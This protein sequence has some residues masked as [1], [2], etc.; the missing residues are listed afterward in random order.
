[1]GEV[2]EA[3]DGASG[4][5][6]AVKVLANAAHGNVERFLR[7]AQI[8][9]SITHP[10][11][12]RHL[13]HGRAPEGQPYLVMEW[14]EGEDLA[15]RLRQR[16]LNLSD[17]LEVGRAV[18]AGLAAA[19]AL[20]VVHRDLKP[21]NIFLCDC[22]PARVKLLDFGL[23]KLHE[24]GDQSLTQTGVILG[25][26]SYMAPEQARGERRLGPRAD[27]FALGCILFACLTRRPPFTG[28][29]S[30]AILAKILFEEAPRL[31][32]L[33][34]GVPPA[35]DALVARML[36]KDPQARP[37]DAAAVAAALD[38]V[39]VSLAPPASS[40]AVAV[41]TAGLAYVAV[42]LAGPASAADAT[43]VGER[44]LVVE[45]APQ[46]V[47]DRFGARLERL[48]DGST[49][50]VFAGAY[51]GDMAQRAA[52][53]ALALRAASTDQPVAVALGRGEV[54]G[55]LPTGE[56]IDS[57]SRL[58]PSEPGIRVD[59]SGQALLEGR[60]VLRPDA[61]GAWLL[62]ARSEDGSRR[63]LGRPSLF[64]GRDRE[65]ATL[66]A[67]L[68]ETIADSRARAVLVLG[69]AGVGKSRLRQE[70]L[71]HVDRA[72]VEVWRADCDP[73]RAGSPYGLVAELLRPPMQLVEG[74]PIAVRQEK[75]LARVARHVPGDALAV[76]CFLGELVGA[77]FSDADSVKLRAARQD[78]MLM[79]DQVRA[80]WGAWLAAEA[81][82]R[83]LLLVIED[84]HAADQASLKLLAG[85]LRDLE[86]QPLFLLGMGRPEAREVVGSLW[87][88]AL[89]V[90]R[91]REL[92]RGSCE[93]LVRAALGD[94]VAAATLAELVGRAEGNAFFLEELV[95]AVAEGERERIP[96]TVLATIDARLG[97]LSPELRQL[98]RAASVFGVTFWQDGVAALLGQPAAT[99]APLLAELGEG[100]WL[101]PRRQSRFA[102]QPEL[103]FRHALVR[104]AAYATLTEV[105]RARGHR[106]AAAWLAHAGEPDAL[107]L[108]GHSLRG[109]DRPQAARWLTHAAEQALAVNDFQAAIGHADQAVEHGVDAAYL[110]RAR[111]VQAEARNWRAEHAEAKPLALEAAALLRHG[112][113]SW[114]H[115]AH[116]S[117]WASCA[118]GDYVAGGRMSDELAAELRWKTTG[119]LV[120][121][122]CASATNLV[123]G[124]RLEQANLLIDLAAPA[125]ATLGE[126]L[127]AAWAA[128]ARGHAAGVG[129]R[130]D[131]ARLLFAQAAEHY[132]AAGDERNACVVRTNVGFLCLELGDFA[133]GE[134]ELAAALA[135]ATRM[136]IAMVVVGNKQNLA[137][138]LFRQGRFDEA[139]AL[140]AEVI[141]ASRAGSERRLEGASRVYLARVEEGAGRLPAARAEA[142]AAVA[143][144]GELPSLRAYAR[145]V[146][147]RA[148]LGTGAPAAALALAQAA[149]EEA[150]TLGNLEEGDAYVR[151]AHA[152]AL[153]ADGQVEAARAAI[154]AAAE[155]LRGRA[156]A[157]GDAATRAR[158]LE[159][160][161]EHRQTLALEAAWGRS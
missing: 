10:S 37:A 148:A 136:G 72:D 35:L 77:H 160:V 62:G 121:S 123:L 84:V 118:S 73:L 104:E 100:E 124:G 63:L 6:V 30:T 12:V 152:E 87:D 60:F 158:F 133:A 85:S 103:I 88:R 81:A 18:C 74:E 14:L 116:H 109:D 4:E 38:L 110:G 92:S 126:P 46:D 43:M 42:V 80:A 89:E 8:L 65:V 36:A 29:H 39:D 138:A 129:G 79:G 137:L 44:A 144:L 76:A 127:I 114:A 9:A 53:A 3:R 101:S 48:V 94:D 1:M 156:Q 2:H 106:A 146:A 122:A 59:A 40:P 151:L 55:A 125:A 49:V 132:V 75:L 108:A 145:G 56:A 27:V 32:D 83:P 90:L 45:A 34:P 102:G 41:G 105:D 61:A 141:E 91:L 95:R 98:L 57:A 119:P 82:A 71:H 28:S 7:E 154:G 31:A 159:A 78:A 47:A 149:M 97:R 131:E 96:A 66:R 140:L 22:D 54:S 143:L 16:A 33:V 157:M 24:D 120:A 20:G 128:S 142:E 58:L 134:V 68:D 19:H 50:L 150:A 86:H 135:T 67:L 26:P 52:R 93:R 23:A 5:R 70:F 15:T 111:L 153:H 161:A 51:P 115:A 112:D 113:D 21:S 117:V 147:A 99:V 13:G 69:A 130:L 17:T 107:V 139:R 155:L 11:I 25:T 64:V